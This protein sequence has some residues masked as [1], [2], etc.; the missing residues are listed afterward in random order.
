MLAANGDPRKHIEIE[1]QRYY[2][3]RSTTEFEQFKQAVDDVFLYFRV[4]NL[5]P[6]DF[7]LLESF[8][9]VARQVRLTWT[10]R[11]LKKKDKH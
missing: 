7:D 5:N 9:P 2:Y 11:N 3:E 6:L 4:S 8:D 1:M 10:K